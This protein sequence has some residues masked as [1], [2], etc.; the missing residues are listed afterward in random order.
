QRQAR[1][2]QPQRQRIQGV[3]VQRPGVVKLRAL[4]DEH[5]LKQRRAA[6]FQP[7]RALRR[8]PL[9]QQRQRVI[10]MGNRAQQRLPGLRQE[11]AKGQRGRRRAGKVGAQRH[12][13]DE[14]AHQLLQFRT[15]A[16]GH[17]GADQNI[18]LARV[19]VEQRL[20]SRQ[21]GGRQR[22][23][24]RLTERVQGG[25]QL[26]A[27]APGKRVTGSGRMQS[28]GRARPIGGQIQAREVAG[29]LLEPV[30]AQARALRAFQHRAL[31]V[32]VI[33]VLHGLRGRGV[34]A[35]AGFGRVKQVQLLHQQRHRP[36]VGDR[37]A[38]RQQEH[39]LLGRALQGDQAQQR[40]ALQ[41]KGAVGRLG[42]IIA[43]GVIAPGGNVHHLQRDRQLRQGALP[44]LPVL[45]R[46]DG[47]QSG[48]A[49]D[50]PL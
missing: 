24:V 1:A 37:V 42:Q 45:H 39:V 16:S 36:E 32:D 21:Q 18:G 25:R 5:R 35:R 27:K 26:R 50:Q 23:A 22:Y 40:A 14:V 20:E 11:V 44:R 4:H 3:G 43:Q 31:P 9:R 2:G 8:K 46:E 38:D 29:K 15:F 34:G 49:G 6:G 33:D 28:R 13:V 48:G 30:V 12:R 47:A 7:Q 19:A 10:L 41:V 17:H